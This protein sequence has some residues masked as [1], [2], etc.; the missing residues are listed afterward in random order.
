MEM[1]GD[2]NKRLN[3]DYNKGLLWQLF[4]AE[5]MTYSEYVTYVNEAKH[6]VNPIRDIILFENYFLEL[7]TMVKWWQ[8]PLAYIPWEY[9]CY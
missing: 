9:Y 7:F 1:D 8:I 2:L 5:G 4:Q 6:L 3:F